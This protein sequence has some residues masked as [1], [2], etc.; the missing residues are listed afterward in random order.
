MLKNNNNKVKQQQKQKQK[1]ALRNIFRMN[2]T[3]WPI[4]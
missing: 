2:S 4:T 1:K 3:H